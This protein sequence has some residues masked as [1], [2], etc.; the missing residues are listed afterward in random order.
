M[1]LKSPR[2]KT[3]SELPDT[4]Q[5]ELIQEALRAVR[6]AMEC[7]RGAGD[8][9]VDEDGAGGEIDRIDNSY[10]QVA[11]GHLSDAEDELERILSDLEEEN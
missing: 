8:H 3:I 1:K 9:V 2:I 10:A 6:G 5:R 7:L 4:E 11:I